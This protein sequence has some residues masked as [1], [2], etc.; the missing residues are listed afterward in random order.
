MPTIETCNSIETLPDDEIEAPVGYT[1]RA[2][3]W[4]R[5]SSNFFRWIH[6]VNSV[7]RKLMVHELGWV[8]ASRNNVH[9]DKYR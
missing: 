7:G 6:P 2:D 9:L 5:D 1:I 4:V 3:D 8:M